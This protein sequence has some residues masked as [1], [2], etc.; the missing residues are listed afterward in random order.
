MLGVAHSG[1]RHYLAV[2]RWCTRILFTYYDTYYDFLQHIIAKSSCKKI[3]NNFCLKIVKL[4]DYQVRTCRG[5]LEHSKQNQEEKNTNTKKLS[6]KN[7]VRPDGGEGEIPQQAV[8]E[9]MTQW[10]RMPLVTFQCYY[11]WM[12]VNF[13]FGGKYILVLHFGC[14]CKING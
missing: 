7:K 9:A 11:I 6:W 3:I 10:R 2:D 13:I 8:G 1:K 5:K 12:L 4:F 14:D